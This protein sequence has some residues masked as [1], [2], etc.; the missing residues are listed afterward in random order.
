MIELFTLE[1]VNKSPASFDPQ[2]LWAFQDRHMRSIPI[3]SKVPAAL[4]YLQA[5]KLVAE[6]APVGIGAYVGRVIAAAGDRIKTTGDILMFS[7]FFVADDALP[8][9][10]PDFDKQ[11]KAPGA[12]ARAAR[13]RGTPRGRRNVRA[14]RARER[15]QGVRRG[16]RAQ[17][18]PAHPPAAAGGHRANR[19]VGA[20]RRACDPRPR[21]LARADQAGDRGGRLTRAP[22]LAVAR[23][24][25]VD[26]R[27][28]HVRRRA[29]T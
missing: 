19:R 9:D 26:R 17:G 24:A 4:E 6:P 21:A 5:A 11:L 15:A 29:L 23:A 14:G 8:C 1:R 28:P 12:A 18:W 27:K 16:A 10:G 3:E 25:H 2:K 20:L 7:E 22:R 13:F